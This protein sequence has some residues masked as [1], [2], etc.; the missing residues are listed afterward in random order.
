MKAKFPATINI[1]ALI[2]TI[3]VSYLSVT[4][5]FNHNC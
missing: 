4:G 1:I 2:L 5:I 3:A